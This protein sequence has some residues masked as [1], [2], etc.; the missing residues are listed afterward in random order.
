M[1]SQNNFKPFM[2]IMGN[3]ASVE[4]AMLLI[5]LINSLLT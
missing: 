3:I 5:V 1:V 4:K 2:V